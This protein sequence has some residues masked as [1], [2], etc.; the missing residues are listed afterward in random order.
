[1]AVAGVAVA[2]VLAWMPWPPLMH[3]GF[4]WIPDPVRHLINFLG[5]EDF[6]CN[7]SAFFLLTLIAQPVFPRA[8]RAGRLRC[9]GWL[10][11][12]VVLLEC[13]QLFLPH[14]FFDVQ[15]ILAGWV[16][17]AAG[18]LPWLLAFRGAPAP[19]PKNDSI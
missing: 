7:A 5:N 6:L 17:V 19:A 4:T 8:G 13:G 12:L 1:M 11:G 16:G 10:A 14:R 15:D 2:A 3:V 9:A 18:S